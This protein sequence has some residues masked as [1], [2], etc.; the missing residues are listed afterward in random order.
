[1]DFTP[2]LETKPKRDESG[3]LTLLRKSSKNLSPARVACFPRF[4]SS[5][6]TT[7]V[8]SFPMMAAESRKPIM[9]WRAPPEEDHSV[10][11]APWLC[12]RDDRGW[13][14]I[15]RANSAS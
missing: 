14:S 8:S 2:D 11:S 6:L 10:K 15:R 5:Q 4:V 3:V 1:M 13:P 9:I 7:E 12:F